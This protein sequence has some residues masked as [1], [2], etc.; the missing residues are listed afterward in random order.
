[1]KSLKKDFVFL[2]CLAKGY[3]R[4]DVESR[5]KLIKIAE[6]F[7]QNNP[8]NIIPKFTWNVSPVITAVYDNIN[9]IKEVI[10]ILKREDFGISIVVSGIISE[11]SNIISEMGLNMHTIHLSLGIFGKKEL[12]PPEQKILE[13][14]TMC[15]HHCIST[16]SVEH[17]I[18]L[19]REGKISI[20][21]AAQNLA[22]PCVCG[23][24]NTS[25]AIGILNEL[26]V[27]IK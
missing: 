13:I 25:R 14:T 26:K 22:K 19:I 7:S 8:V 1:M 10:Q 4:E 23:I 16:Q 2:T 12:L 15:G 20:E 5:K 6:I 24:F 17:N 3:N 27:I 18:N 21:K 11:I 9:A